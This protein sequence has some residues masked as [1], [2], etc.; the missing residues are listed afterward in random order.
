V[1]QHGGVV[2]RAG[3][4]LFFLPATIAI[5]V[6]PLPEIGRV[7]GAPEELRGVALVDGQMIPVVSTW[8]ADRPP[9]DAMLV[10]SVFGELVGVVGV[11][12]IATGRFREEAGEVVHD[13]RVARSFDLAALLATV[14]G[15]RWAV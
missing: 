1:S 14:Q 4:E 9:P 3:E 13:D 7:P 6:I 15:G 12:V 10:C 8:R 5:K 2:F 11:D